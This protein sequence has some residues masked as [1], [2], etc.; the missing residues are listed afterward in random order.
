C[1]SVGGLERAIDLLDVEGD[2]LRLL[3]ELL[4][5]LYRLLKLLKRRVW[6]AR[7]VA[8]LIDQHCRFVL[9]LRDLLV[10][11]LERPRSRQ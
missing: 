7:K 9:K 3:Q 2:A 10:D 6:Q 11:L 8:G 1:I 5:A 4:R